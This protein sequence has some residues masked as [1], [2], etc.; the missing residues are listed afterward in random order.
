MCDP[1]KEPVEATPGEPFTSGVATFVNSCRPSPQLMSYVNDSA[2]SPPL[3]GI[4]VLSGLSKP[5]SLKLTLK[6]PDPASLM[7][8]VLGTS[9]ESVGATLFTV[10][11]NVSV[12]KP[13]MSSSLNET[14][15][16]YVPLSAY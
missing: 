7:V 8:V 1:P 11:T 12:L 15:T 4:F 14:E 3:G 6:L 5:G 10:M 16:V 9:P 13:A 2:T